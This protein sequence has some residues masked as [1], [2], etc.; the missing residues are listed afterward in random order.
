MRG[1]GEHDDFSYVPRELLAAY[2][3]RDPLTVCREILL[4][5][6]LINPPG[7]EALEAEVQQAVDQ[8]Q[9]AAFRDPPPSPS[10]LLKGVYAGE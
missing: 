6:G 2:A 9:Q 5:R 8:A 7:L 1:H 4:A 10:T 3:A